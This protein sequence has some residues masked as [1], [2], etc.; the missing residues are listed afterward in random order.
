MVSKYDFLKSMKTMLILLCKMGV[1]SVSILSHIEVYEYFITL[2]HKTK[3]QKYQ[4]TAEKFNLQPRQVINI[5]NDM[6]S[7]VD[8]PQNS[9]IESIKITQR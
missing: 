6:T 1:V 2:N 7:G 4:D 8:L 3:M 9:F 5:I